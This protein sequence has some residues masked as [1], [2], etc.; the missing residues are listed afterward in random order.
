MDQLRGFNCINYCALALSAIRQYR[1][2]QISSLTFG[3]CFNNAKSIKGRDCSRIVRVNTPNNTSRFWQVE[4]IGKT[5][6]ENPGIMT[7]E[8]V[9]NK[10]R[11][12][13][14]NNPQ[15]VKLFFFTKYIFVKILFL[16]HIVYYKSSN[17]VM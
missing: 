10:G 13:E 2:V 5:I 8:S 1:I 12:T 14:N 9:T 4:K 3:C 15:S 6:R 17:S 16:L 11:R 7:G